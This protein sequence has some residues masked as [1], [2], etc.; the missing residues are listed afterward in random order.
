MEPTPREVVGA[1]LLALVLI[2]LVALLVMA[3]LP[4]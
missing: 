1:G 4:A 2:V 3:S